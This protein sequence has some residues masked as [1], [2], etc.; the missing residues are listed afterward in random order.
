MRRCGHSLIMFLTTEKTMA[1][2]LCFMAAKNQK[3]YF[4]LM[5]LLR[6]P[7][8]DDV[9]FKPTVDRCPETEAWTGN[10]GVITTLIPQVKFDPEKT[11]CRDLRS[12][13]HV[14]V[15]YRRLKEKR[16]SRRPHNHVFGAKNEM[17]SRKM[18]TLP[19]KPSLRLQGWTQCLIIQKLKEFRR[20]CKNET[21]SSFL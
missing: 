4:S 18:R 20:R 13:N 3:N 16:R 1:K 12:A 10:I 21:Q 8:G 6:S 2:L 19:D 14:Q 17:W 15:R 5:N 7:R 9:D 11:I